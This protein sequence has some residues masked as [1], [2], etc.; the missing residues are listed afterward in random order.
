MEDYVPGSISQ[1]LNPSAPV[2]DDIIETGLASSSSSK[3]PPP[4][5]PPKRKLQASSD[6]LKVSKKARASEEANAKHSHSKSR[7]TLANSHRRD[8]VSRKTS[9]HH[10][11]SV[12]DDEE[13]DDEKLSEEEPP[14]YEEK[15][16][17]LTDEDNDAVPQQ[18]TQTSVSKFSS[19]SRSQPPPPRSRHAAAARPAGEEE[20]EGS[21]EKESSEAAEKRIR[22]AEERNERT[23]FVGNVPIGI[24]RKAIE[25]VFSQYG[26]VESV[27]CRSIAFQNP[28]LPRKAAY[29][30]KNFHEQRD[31]MNAYVVFAQKESV[32]KALACNGQLIGDKHVHVD[33]AATPSVDHTKSVFVGNL[34]FISN[35]EQ[36][37]EL[38]KPIGNVEAVRIVR[39]RVSNVGKGFGYVRFQSTADAKSALALHGTQFMGRELRVFRALDKEKAAQ[40]SKSPKAFFLQRT[41]RKSGSTDGSKAERNQ[42]APKNGRKGSRAFFE[43]DHTAENALKHGAQVKHMI[44]RRSRAEQRD[45]SISKARAKPKTKS[46]DPKVKAAKHQ[47]KMAKRGAAGKASSA[48]H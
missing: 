6:A 46:R 15:N 40:K 37:R 7:T 24:K 13:D 27:R 34:P 44:R 1:F 25:K 16:D 31:S 36:L 12:E 48:K 35:E 14:E 43:G 19:S 17:D 32:E 8:A 5:P 26:D 28:K 20:L 38:F 21:E 3:S 11:H 4:P 2:P 42:S 45:R 18:E 22:E 33:R 10:N 29:V 9:G 39:D 23:I 30:L 41:I 47:K